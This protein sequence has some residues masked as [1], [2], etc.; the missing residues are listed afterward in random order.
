MLAAKGLTKAQGISVTTHFATA[1]I[2]VP[3]IFKRP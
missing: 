1:V 3:V 2:L